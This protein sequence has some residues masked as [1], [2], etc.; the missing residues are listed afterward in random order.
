MHRLAAQG[1]RWQ[2][3]ESG[4]SQPPGMGRWRQSLAGTLAVAI[5]IGPLLAVAGVLMVFAL[6]MIFL[7]GAVAALFFMGLAMA[8]IHALVT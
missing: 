7:F 4:N 6:S 3:R 2:A 5:V 8:G 1:A